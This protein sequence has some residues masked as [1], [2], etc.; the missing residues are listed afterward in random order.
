M[1]TCAFILGNLRISQGNTSMFSYKTQAFPWGSWLHFGGEHGSQFVEE[2]N[3]VPL[4]M[5]QFPRL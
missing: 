1:K 3:H 5:Q 4:G 2:H